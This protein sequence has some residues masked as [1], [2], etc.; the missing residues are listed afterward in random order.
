MP[1]VIAVDPE[2]TCAVSVTAFPA[3]TVDAERVS[4]VVV[5]LLVTAVGC[6]L[7]GIERMGKGIGWAA[8]PDV[9]VFARTWPN[10]GR[11]AKNPK[12]QKARSASQ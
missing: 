9:C 1:G 12:A 3:F 6:K 4:V 11:A 5:A 8:T 2:T 7:W 10:A